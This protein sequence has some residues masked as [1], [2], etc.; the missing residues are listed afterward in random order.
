M[1]KSTTST[2]KGIAI[3][4]VFLCHVM[5]SWG[6]GIRIFN[7]LGGIGVAIFYFFLVMDLMSLGMIITEIIISNQKLF[8]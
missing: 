7:P 6:Q 2:F 5:G 8:V 1:T 4:L 3:I